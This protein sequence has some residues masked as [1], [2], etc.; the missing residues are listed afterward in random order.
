M[1]VAIFYEDSGMPRQQFGLH[2]LVVRAVYEK[3]ASSDAYFEFDRRLHG[4]PQNGNS[5]VITACK[6]AN[7]FTNRGYGTFAVLDKDQA[8][9]L[10]GTAATCHAGLRAATIA[11]GVLPA[12]TVIFL[13][14]N[15]ES[16][17]CAIQASGLLEIE[18]SVFQK[19]ITSKD[20]TSRDIIL[21][22]ASGDLDLHKTIRRHI[23]RDVPSFEYLIDKIAAFL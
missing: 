20:L 17:L 14:R 3:K 19:A 6:G 15:T 8:P 5:K 7:Y 4:V 9:R 12:T 1:P 22:K 13:D 16:V 21:C 2:R 23:F 18:Q 11:A 10:L